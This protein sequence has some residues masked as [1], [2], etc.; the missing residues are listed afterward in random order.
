[1]RDHRRRVHRAARPGGGRL[2]GAA[3][4]PVA[5][6]VPPDGQGRR[7][8][9]LRPDGPAGGRGREDD[10]ATRTSG[11]SASS[12]SSPAPCART[13]RCT[14]RATSP[15]FFGEDTG[16][17]DHDDDERIGVL[18]YPFGQHLVAGSALVAGDIGCVSR[19]TTAETGDTLSS[20]DAPRVL[21]PWSMPD[22]AAAGR[23]RG[24][25]PLR[26]GQ[27]LRR[28]GAAGR[29]GPEPA[30]RAA[31]PR[32]S[33]WCSGCSARRT[34][35]WPS[36][37]CSRRYGVARRDARAG[38]PAARDV[39]RPRPGPRSARQAVRRPRPVR[40]LRHRGGAAARRAPASSS[41]TRSWAAPYPASSSPASR[42]AC[43]A[44]MERGLRSGPP[45]G[46]PAGDP[47]RRQVAQ[48]RQLRHG[49]PER[50]RAG[51]AR[52]RRRRRASRCSSRTTRSPCS[53]S[54]TTSAR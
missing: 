15:S 31:T 51:A 6:G 4:A 42:R 7:H 19:L 47:G 21:K 14:S 28:A 10:A 43:V 20:P 5:R 30:G 52:G 25:D 13:F 17:E 11:G 48:R 2:P 41:S 32:P 54:T 16:H 3:R 34:P 29:R 35:R 38:G 9:D 37:G 33:R 39:R 23:D 50:R 40:H 44:Q 45:V 26:R 22:P 36:T 24:G 27:A 1:M 18:S 49:V 53:S 46:R 8:R 12:A